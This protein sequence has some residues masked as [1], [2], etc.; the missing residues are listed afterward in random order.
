M[1]GEDSADPKSIENMPDK[2]YW[3]EL[4]AG[5]LAGLRFGISKNFLSDSLYKQAVDIIVAAG[6]I[7]IEYEPGQVNF[8]N[9]TKVLGGDMKTDL[10]KYISTYASEEIKFQS[11][12]DLAEYNKLDTLTRIPYRQTLF[13]GMVNENVSEAELTEMK[14]K[15]H[16]EG[17]GFFEKPLKEFSLDAILSISN[18]YAG[19]AAVAEYPCLTVP[20]GFTKRGEPNTLTFTARPFEEDKLLKMGYAFEQA[21][22]LRRAPEEIR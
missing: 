16:D 15:L 5:T 19:Y 7:A 10:P 21:A 17:V 6:G 3:E 1:T 22:K 8:E 9:F 13:T 4:K 18:R 14:A 12:A 2:K 11:I 20:M